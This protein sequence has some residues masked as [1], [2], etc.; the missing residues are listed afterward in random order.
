MKSYRRRAWSVLLVLN[1]A[2]ISYGGNAVYAA[3]LAYLSFENSSFQPDTIY[4]WLYDPWNNLSFRMPYEG[5]SSYRYTWLSTTMSNEGQKSL[6]IRLW[7]NPNK[8]E[9]QRI[10]FEISND[11]YL[12]Q[13]IN[14]ATSS[15]YY[16][17]AMYI[18]PQSPA[19]LQDREVIVSSDLR[20]LIG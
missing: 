6:G 10:E 15:R 5:D 2:V 1:I 13:R 11:L 4:H 20:N 19:S 8:Q 9:K 14:H 17:I 3:P 16:G 12:T 18:H 7:E